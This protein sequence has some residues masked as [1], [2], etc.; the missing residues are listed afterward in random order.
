MADAIVNL[1]LEHLVKIT[2]RTI[3][4]QLVKEEVKKLQSN[5]EAIQAVLLD[6]EE[7]QVK[8][9]AVR[10]W[11]DQLKDTS[12]DMEDVLDKWNTE[13]MKLQVEGDLEDAPAPMQKIFE[14]EEG[15][16]QNSIL[17]CLASLSINYC[18]TLRVLPDGLLQG[19]KKLQHLEIFTSHLLEERYSKGTGEDWQ[20]ISH[21]PN[22]KFTDSYLQGGPLP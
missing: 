20:K 5:L 13:I 9:K 11:L 8:D 1:A 10:R 4:E 14:W 3:E 17:P 19:A 15:D 22:I 2:A 7:R 16:Y 6:A 18:G 21:I 12:Y